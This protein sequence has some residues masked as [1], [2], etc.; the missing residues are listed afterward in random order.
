MNP[1]FPVT[2]TCG[3]APFLR[4]FVHDGENV[5]T[6]QPM[7]L[8]QGS[9]PYA[10]HGGVQFFACMPADTQA[11]S[12]MLMFAM[13]NTKG[14]ESRSFTITPFKEV[15]PAAE[16]A[17]AVTCVKDVPS[18]QQ[19]MEGMEAVLVHSINA[20]VQHGDFLSM[21]HSQ[22]SHPPVT[23]CAILEHPGTPICCVDPQAQPLRALPVVTVC[24][25]MLAVCTCTA[26][27]PDQLLL[28][29][30]PGHCH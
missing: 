7:I 6:I 27:Q 11:S 9:K 8:Q 13:F 18:C 22:S 10:V 19:Y 14:I 16:H 29:R 20:L 21:H 25:V 26:G 12:K 5:M 17:L 15:R 23:C 2:L 3:A 28:S 1:S 4:R 30:H 24:I